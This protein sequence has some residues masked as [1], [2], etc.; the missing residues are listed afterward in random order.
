MWLGMVSQD[1]FFSISGIDFYR[2]DF[3]S[4]I[5]ANA[6]NTHFAVFGG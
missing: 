3:W 2:S 6:T 1:L 5:F 4:W